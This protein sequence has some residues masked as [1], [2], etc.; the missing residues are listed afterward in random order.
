MT[1]EQAA[2]AARALRALAEVL[3]EVAQ[4]GDAAPP[5]RAERPAVAPA[6]RRRRTVVV[7]PPDVPANDRDRALA[8]RILRR[9][10]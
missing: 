4:T 6:R 1:A 10:L 7:S 3:D 8:R 2:R 5:V 9:G